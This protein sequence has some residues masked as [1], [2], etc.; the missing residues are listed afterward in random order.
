MLYY[1]GHLFSFISLMNLIITPIGLTL[2]RY[3]L[4][5]ESLF[6]IATAVLRVDTVSFAFLQ[7]K[8][9]NHLDSPLRLLVHF[10]KNLCIKALYTLICCYG[11][12]NINMYSCAINR[13]L[14]FTLLPYQKQSD[15]Q[16][17][18]FFI[19]ISFNTNP[20]SINFCIT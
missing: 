8:R 12:L 16:L 7:T 3:C 18:C 15:L 13:K 10:S 4:F 9:Q 20:D 14:Y 6:K 1:H 2:N 11:F 5:G 17:C 19:A